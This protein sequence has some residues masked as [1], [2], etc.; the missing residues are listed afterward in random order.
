[1]RL[2]T[3]QR[4]WVDYN[5]KQAEQRIREKTGLSLKLQ[6]KPCAVMPDE[7]IAMM[8]IIAKELH[9]TMDDYI[10]DRSQE[11]VD[12]RCIAS[13]MIRMHYPSVR[14]TTIA[15]N[16]GYS[17]H[18]MIVD[19]SQRGRRRIRARDEKFCPKYERV[20]EAVNK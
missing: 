16:M 9:L 8:G 15:A 2:S 20:S 17:D 14:L 5:I 19:L 7:A 6:M 4:K 12:L 11:Y 10:S 13:L 18:S 1:M 3:E